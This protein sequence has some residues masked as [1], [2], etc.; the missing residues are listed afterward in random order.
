MS[1]FTNTPTDKAFCEVRDH[2]TKDNTLNKR[3]N[4]NLDDIMEI[5]SLF[6][7]QNTFSS[8][9]PHISKCLARQCAA[10]CHLL[11]QTTI[12][13]ILKNEAFATFPFDSKPTLWKSY[14]DDVFERIKQGQLQYLT[15]H[16]NMVDE[17]GSIKFTQEEECE[18]TIPFLDT[19]VV[20]KPDRSIK[21]LVNR[22][23]PTWTNIYISRHTTRYNTSLG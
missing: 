16:L 18:G 5:A 20:M 3:A 7:L 6:Y 10:Q 2:L 4:L 13:E 22:R 11:L 17:T 19:H 21:L 14:V 9:A 23:R 15:D 1:L 12:M 8:V